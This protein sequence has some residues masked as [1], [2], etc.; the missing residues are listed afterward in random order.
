MLRISSEDGEVVVPCAEVVEAAAKVEDPDESVKLAEEE[1]V[2][3]EEPEEASVLM[4]AEEVAVAFVVDAVSA[5]TS[6]A[7]AT[8]DAAAR[9][10]VAAIMIL[11]AFVMCMMVA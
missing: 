9:V 11:L 4:D 5:N 8:A 3:V 2:R 6:G 7:P 1:E 10:S